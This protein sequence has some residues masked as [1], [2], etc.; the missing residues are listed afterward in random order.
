MKANNNKQIN[1]TS[2][3]DSLEITY[4]LLRISNS[5]TGSF[6]LVS[7]TTSRYAKHV[8]RQRHNANRCKYSCPVFYQS[9]SLQPIFQLFLIISVSLCMHREFTEA[10]LKRKMNLKRLRPYPEWEVCK[11]VVPFRF[12]LHFTPGIAI[13]QSNLLHLAQCDK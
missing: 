9:S 4:H 6:T 5:Q 1:Q 7:I 8:E 11:Y 10:L 3:I 13:L 2:F 12:L